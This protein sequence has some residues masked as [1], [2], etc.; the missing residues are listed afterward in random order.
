LRSAAR[1]FRGLLGLVT[2]A[3][4]VLALLWVDRKDRNKI[5]ALRV[6]L[7]AGLLAVGMA[8]WSVLPI[9]QASASVDRE[10]GWF[11][12]AIDRSND[13]PYGVPGGT[14]DGAN[15][16]HMMRLPKAAGMWS[17]AG[18]GP[19]NVGWVVRPP[20]PGRYAL[21]VKY[22]TEGRYAAEVRL[23]GQPLF[24]ALAQISGDEL[25]PKWF[26]EGIVELHAGANHLSFH[27]DSALPNIDA[28]RL[29]QIPAR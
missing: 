3:V 29:T 21:S 6:V 26:E 24:P 8:L 25:K 16:N 13:Y 12:I 11:V 2:I 10:K 23:E 9:S 14:F 19:Y 7:I 5:V 22:A 17:V 18:N 1:D 15:T 20:R 27:S 28:L 4:V